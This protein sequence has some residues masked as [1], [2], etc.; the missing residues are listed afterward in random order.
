MNT[1][2]LHEACLLIKIGLLEGEA[3]MEKTL[4]HFFSHYGKFPHRYNKGLVQNMVSPL[5]YQ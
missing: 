4:G 1:F 2:V 5:C 3:I